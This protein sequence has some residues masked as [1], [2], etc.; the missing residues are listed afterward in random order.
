M[1][2]EAGQTPGGQV[3]YVMMPSISAPPP[4]K[5]QPVSTTG[6]PGS[7]GSKQ[8]H[9]RPIMQTNL[10][11]NPVQTRPA[12]QRLDQQTVGME[13]ARILVPESLL[14]HS[15]GHM[16][17][18]Y[19]PGTVAQVPVVQRASA[20]IKLHP[21][22]LG[23]VSSSTHGHFSLPPTIDA[24]LGVVS[25]SAPRAELVGKRDQGG[26]ILAPS[27]HESG[28]FPD[29]KGDTLFATEDEFSLSTTLF[30]MSLDH[31]GMGGFSAD[32][33]SRL[34]DARSS[35]GPGSC[36]PSRS[37][38]LQ[39]RGAFPDVRNFPRSSTHGVPSVGARGFFADSERIVQNGMGNIGG[40]IAGVGGASLPPET[41]QFRMG[42]VHRQPKLDLTTSVT[43]LLFSPAE[44]ATG[45]SLVRKT[46]IN[47]SM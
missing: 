20:G 6:W 44:L 41:R 42:E 46:K 43:D 8:G 47:L 13:G 10:Q 34:E 1:T 7:P 33:S 32:L 3:Q 29:G 22:S 23:V 26:G 12:H 31:A 5:P 19:E 45:I 25:S 40:A 11:L 28:S 18:L 2:P 38:T 16:N 14:G 27:P 24:D 36:V 39:S 17:Q 37:V 35:D 30:N 9:L 21:R 4:M 15:F